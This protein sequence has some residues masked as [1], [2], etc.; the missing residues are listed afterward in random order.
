MSEPQGM[1]L[2]PI[3]ARVFAVWLAA[4]HLATTDWLEWEDVPNLGKFTFGRLEE[5]AALVA[6]EVAEKARRLAEHHDID[7]A[8]LHEQATG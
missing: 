8:F 6:A 4:R 1:D 2:S 7:P 3:E 5:A